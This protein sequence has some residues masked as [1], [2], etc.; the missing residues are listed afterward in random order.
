M[1]GDWARGALICQMPHESSIPDPSLID[2]YF[3]GEARPSEIAIVEQWLAAHPDEGRALRIVHADV[4]A[5][6]GSLPPFDQDAEVAAI[7]KYSVET[8][9]KVS[10]RAS[11]KGSYLYRLSALGVGLCALVL[12]GIAI[13]NYSKGMHQSPRVVYVTGHGERT[14]V[15]LPDGSRTILAPNSKLTYA[16]GSKGQ[17]ELDLIGQAY[18]IVQHDAK[19]VFVVRTGS[20]HT[21]V[22]GTSFDVRYYAGDSTVQIVVVDGKVAAK[23]RGAPVVL[24]AGTESQLTDSTAVIATNRNT[25]VAEAWTHGR[26]I[27]DKVPVTAVLQALHQWYGY[28]FRLADTALASRRVTT[29]LPVSDTA[30]TMAALKALLNVTLRFEGSTITLYPLHPSHTSGQPLHRWPSPLEIQSEVGK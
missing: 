4:A 6:F 1:V 19:H 14:Q 9:P 22:L 17:R 23:G 21:T 7:V 3:A 2:R 27:F 10:H 24:A 26:M 20:V 5:P 18:F 13:L 25:D 16:A 11:N 12:A 28:N 30:T 29:M 15:M 8:M